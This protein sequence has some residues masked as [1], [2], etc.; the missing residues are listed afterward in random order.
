VGSQCSSPFSRSAMERSVAW[1]TTQVAQHAATDAGAA[2]W[3]WRRGVGGGVGEDVVDI[4]R[5]WD[6]ESR[7]YDCLTTAFNAVLRVLADAGDIHTTRQLAQQ[8]SVDTAKDKASTD[9]TYEYS[10]CEV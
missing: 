3:G 4:Q 1:A 9:V 6:A 8:V 5:A 10:R 2:A 7:W